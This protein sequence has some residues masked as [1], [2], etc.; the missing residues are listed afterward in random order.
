MSAPPPHTKKNWAPLYDTAG[1][2]PQNISSGEENEKDGDAARFGFIKS[3]ATENDI[4]NSEQTVNNEHLL[5]TLGAQQRHVEWTGE[6]FRVKPMRL[7][8]INLA[9][10]QDR[11]RIAVANV[12]V[13]R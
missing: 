3:L 7:Y 13:H 5:R 8:R 11:R 4:S 9:S 6:V 2:S 1:W 12:Q 10:F